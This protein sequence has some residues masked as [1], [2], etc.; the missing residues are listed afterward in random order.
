MAFIDLA[1]E[2]YSVRKFSDRPVEQEKLDCIL[3]AALVAPSAKNDQAWRIYVA[4]SEEALAKLNGLSRCIFGAPVVLVIGYDTTEEWHNP[5]EEGIHSGDQDASIVATHA[6]LEAW[7]LGVGSIWVNLFPNTQTA[8][9]LGLP[10]TFVPVCLM[11][12][13]YAAEDAAPS[14]RHEAHRPIDELVSYL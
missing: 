11:P 14:P 5:L 1:R 13:G 2:R 12:M 8:R 6:M 3:E 4:R 7:E 9:E 10:E